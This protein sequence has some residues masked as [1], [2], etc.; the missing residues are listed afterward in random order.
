[1]REKGINTVDYEN[2]KN[3]LSKIRFLYNEFGNL[4]YR[5]I[6]KYNTGIG[7]ECG[8]ERLTRLIKEKKFSKSQFMADP[9]KGI[10]TFL[11]GFFKDRGG[12]LP[13]VWSEK[14]TVFLMTEISVPC[15][16]I[17][18]EKEVP[19]RH[20]EICSVYCRAEVKGLIQ[21]FEDLFPGIQIQFYNVS[22]RRGPEGDD[23]VE[24]FKVIVP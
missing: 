7:Y 13:K 18:A 15:I 12:N 4:T 20:R 8:I 1:M 21:I 24:A 9:V 3:D 16:T 23:C 19:I 10:E 11:H 17:E 5:A 6:E 2:R 22:S 14:N